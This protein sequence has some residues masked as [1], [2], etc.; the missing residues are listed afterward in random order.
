MGGPTAVSVSQRGGDDH[1]VGGLGPLVARQRPAGVAASRLRA[2]S[3]QRQLRGPCRGVGEP[4]GEI[5]A[6]RLR[7]HL[8]GD[9]GVARTVP[10]GEGLVEELEGGAGEAALVG[11]FG[12]VDER[13]EF[14]G[15][16]DQMGRTGQG[17]YG[18]ALADEVRVPPRCAGPARARGR[19]R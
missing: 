1:T 14:L 15:V 10:E 17:H 5:A 11:G 2:P 4:V 13:F 6:R 7:P 8:V 3:G 18:T 19:A 12:L 9:I 16:D